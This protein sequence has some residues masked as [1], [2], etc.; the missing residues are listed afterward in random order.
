MP[1]SDKE[2]LK[3]YAF[4]LVMLLLIILTTFY[5]QYII[6]FVLLL[7]FYWYVSI[8]VIIISLSSTDF[9]IRRVRIIKDYKA[10]NSVKII[11]R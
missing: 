10:I 2:D 11:K 9:T 4:I 1:F 5:Y 8:P 7:V 6:R 3:C